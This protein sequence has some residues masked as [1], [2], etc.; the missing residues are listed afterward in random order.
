MI[1]KL[2]NPVFDTLEHLALMT[3][4]NNNSGFQFTADLNK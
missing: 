3:M 2:I 1:V 4:N